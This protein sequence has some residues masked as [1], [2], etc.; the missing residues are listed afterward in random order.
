MFFFK[1]IQPNDKRETILFLKSNTVSY[2]ENIDK[3]FYQQNM[4]HSCLSIFLVKK[5]NIRKIVLSFL[6]QLIQC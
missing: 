4:V 2:I 5:L 1:H 6:S 3:S